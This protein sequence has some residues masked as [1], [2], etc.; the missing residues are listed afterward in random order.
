[1]CAY[2]AV[3]SNACAALQSKNID[4]A[5]VERVLELANI[6]TNKN[7]VRITA[8]YSLK[9]YAHTSSVCAYSMSLNS[10]TYNEL[11]DRS[12]ARVTTCHA[13]LGSFRDGYSATLCLL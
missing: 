5:R 4:G 2:D 9:H 12:P 8:Y 1:V 6:A 11:R 10:S 3:V 13:M 7:T